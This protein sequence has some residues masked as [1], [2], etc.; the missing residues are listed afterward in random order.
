MDPIGSNMKGQRLPPP[1]IELGHVLRTVVDVAR[2][3]TSELT[4]KIQTLVLHPCP[5]SSGQ[6]RGEGIHPH[7][8]PNLL[9][10]ATHQSS[11]DGIF[12]LTM[13]TSTQTATAESHQMSDW[14]QSSDQ[15]AHNDTTPPALGDEPHHAQSKTLLGL[16]MP[17]L[18][19][20]A[21]ASFS[22]LIAGVNDGSVGAIIPYVIREYNVNTAIV[23]SVYGATFAGWVFAALTNTLLYQYL[24]LGSM[25]AL[26]AT[27]QILAH[28]LRAWMPPFALLVVTFFFAAVGQAY[29]DTQA[30][31]YVATVKSPHRWLAV[32]HA[33]YSVSSTWYLFY[34]FPAGISVMNLLLICWAFRDSLLIKRKSPAVPADVERTLVDG[35]TSR[36]KDAA[37]FIK[38]TLRR[39][40]VWL[41]SLFYFFY[42][43]S[44][45]TST[46]WVVEY[47]VEVRG[48]NLAQM[49]YVP[50][51]AN[52]GGFL[53]R[54]LLAE[55]T[56]RLGE[57]RMV[58]IYCCLALG[59]QILFWLVPN[60][61]AAS[62]AISLIGFFTGP[63]FAT[64]MNIATKLFPR[65]LH[66]TALAFIFVAAQGG[67]SLF[68]VI[69]GVVASEAGVRTLQP[70]L[71][72]LLAATGVS[73]LLVP[74][75]KTQGN[76]SL[77]QE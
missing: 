63:L 59:L 47:L 52:G 62:V 68:P 24:D 48:G 41:L 67:G 61:I 54:L 73:W 2:R 45:I 72:A 13:G 22:F 5:S 49:G 29:N 3:G 32:I 27:F 66:A 23:S 46:G 10:K 15:R 43:G 58:L 26:G 7:I 25:L 51:G 69:T 34:A 20:V 31:T 40:S 11:V 76:A 30:N 9:V 6:M 64:G 36:R 14:T 17:T 70:I 74:R 50:A 44:A 12:A 33:S 35:D 75:P 19:K 56:Y 39:P 77:H 1:R 21:S 28:A 4:P 42:I 16:D 60:I 55:P 37:T 8:Q 18:L 65:E 57:R 53:G 38:A 71:V